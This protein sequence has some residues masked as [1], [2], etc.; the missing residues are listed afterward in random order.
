MPR[1]RVLQEAGLPSRPPGLRGPLVGVSLAL[2]HW[3][4]RANSP[5]G[6][7]EVR[8]ARAVAASAHSFSQLGLVMRP[9]CASAPPALCRPRPE[10]RSRSAASSSGRGR[11]SRSTSSPTRSGFVARPDRP[12]HLRRGGGRLQSTLHR[13]VLEEET[14][15][16]TREGAA[17]G[18]RFA[19]ALRGSALRSLLPLP[20]LPAADR[21]R[22]RHQRADRG[23]P[24]G[25]LAGE[26]QP[27]AVPRDDGTNQTIWR[28][29]ASDSGVQRV[30]VPADLV[31]SGGQLDYRQR[32]RPTSNLHAVEVARVTP[33]DWVRRST[34]TTRRS[35]CGQP[36]VRAPRG[37]QGVDWFPGPA[38]THGLAN[39]R[40]PRRLA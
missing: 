5:G 15:S 39:P 34:S 4:H 20:E 3:V 40:F 10:S 2:E 38:I 28:R 17:P 6:S 16:V 8:G 36:P 9:A 30:H 7:Q 21:E 27:V 22:L 32:S 29:P 14:M 12:R 13:S 31:C 18:Q 11:S 23:R 35:N 25:V 37:A 26:P 24:R 33:P 19:T 1:Q